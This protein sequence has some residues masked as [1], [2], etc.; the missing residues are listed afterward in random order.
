L[1]LL[2]RGYP[3][4]KLV[5]GLVLLL[6]LVAFW[7]L[8]MYIILAA[9]RS[10]YP[11]E[12]EWIEGAAVDEIRWILQ[13]KALFGEPTVSF[14]PVIYAPLYYILSAGLMKIA[15]IGFFAPRLLSIAASLGIFTLL[16]L[17]VT[18]DKAHPAAGILA[19]GIFAAAYRFTGAWFDLVKT[20]S[21][22]MFFILAAFLI[23]QKYK[24]RPGMITSGLVYVIAFYTKQ[25][26][27]P[28]ILGLCAA[29]LLETR[30]RAW[31]QWLTAG[32]AG[33]FF[34]IVAE[35]VTGGWYSFYTIDILL[36]QQWGGNILFFARSMLAHLA[37]AIFVGLLYPILSIKEV[38]RLKFPGNMWQ[39]LSLAAILVA[40]S[41]AVF[42]KQWSYDNDFIPAVTGVAL[43]CGLG[44]DRFIRLRESSLEFKDFTPP[45]ELETQTAGLWLAGWRLTLMKIAGIGLVFLQFNLLAYN[46]LDQLPSAKDRQVGQEFV[47]LVKSLPGEV[48][49]FN[50]GYYNYLAGK[51][52]YLDSV[53]YGDVVAASRQTKNMSDYL[54]ARLVVDTLNQAISEQ[55]FD[56]I[57][58][59]SH[60]EM[61]QP[62]YIVS[63]DPVIKEPGVFYPITGAMARPQSLMVKN[64]V[65]RGGNLP[66]TDSDLDRLYFQ[67]W[68][69]Q[70][71]ELWSRA[72]QSSVKI[73]L[74]Q[75][76]AYEVTVSLR[77]N[78]LGNNPIVRTFQTSW[79]GEVLRTDVFS[80]CT[81]LIQTID[82]EANQV[83]KDWNLLEF[84]FDQ[85]SDSANGS[86]STGLTAA[87]TR[88]A[89]EQK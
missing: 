58:V 68:T 27:L 67:G 65:V 11:F 41:W 42:L 5:Q 30:G 69:I 16:Y 80:A 73:I 18:Q 43:L 72:R 81:P 24:N 66:L 78:C 52:S 64:P 70:G 32:C 62:Y 37:P 9:I 51:N 86:G 47:D 49:V 48:L 1:S 75:N 17:I 12:L 84:D 88:I 87:V 35:K 15:G 50:H 54:R 61:F 23:G 63:R 77:P 14:L 29:S 46:P 45:P 85:P 21:L 13:G 2:F 53:H 25:V 20:D 76:H 79:N 33:L 3:R 28:I 59:D 36:Y 57:I 22:F 38:R 31:P 82:L 74:E 7:F 71:N 40:A 56:R 60:P 26:A 10:V 83:K 19:A 55:I 44:F 34:F 89:F 4:A 6:V 39:N 8:G